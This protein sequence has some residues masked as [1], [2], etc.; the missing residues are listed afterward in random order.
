MGACSAAE[1]GK[2]TCS[3]GPL[4]R[5][6]DF[7]LTVHVRAQSTNDVRGDGFYGIFVNALDS[8]LVLQEKWAHHFM[9]ILIICRK[10]SAKRFDVCGPVGYL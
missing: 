2:G 9:K 6:E 5:L 7:C 1:T 10:E 3:K 4:I 8:M